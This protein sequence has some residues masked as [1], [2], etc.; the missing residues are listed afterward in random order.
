MLCGILIFVAAEGCIISG[1]GP[2]GIKLHYVIVLGAQVRGTRVSR[3]LKQR[4]D[5]AAA[6]AREN[7]ETS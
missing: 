4:L 6:Y 5:R 7:P 1:M 3:A 2:A